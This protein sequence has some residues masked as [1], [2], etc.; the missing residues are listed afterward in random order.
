MVRHTAIFAWLVAVLVGCVSSPLP[1]PSV[2]A[3]GSAAAQPASTRA[4]T[5]TVAPP[6]TPIEFGGPGSVVLT[7]VADDATMSLVSVG[8]DGSERLLGQP[9]S[10]QNLVDGYEWEDGSISLGPGG[11]VL[12][13]ERTNR[14]DPASYRLIRVNW[15]DPGAKPRLLPNGRA[16]FLA[17]GTI[18]VADE[19]WGTA[20][21]TA[22][23]EADP[24]G[25]ALAAPARVG[26]FGT[27]ADRS[28]L[29]GIRSTETSDSNPIL[30]PVVV[31]RDGAVGP[32]L[33]AAGVALATGRERTIGAGGET[34]SQWFDDGPTGGSSGLSVVRA[35]IPDNGRNIAPG[36]GGV[37]DW[38]WTRDGRA[39][40]MLAQGAIYR[41]DGARTARVLDVPAAV[42]DQYGL[43]IVGLTD[44]GVILS[45]GFEGSTF[46]AFDGGPRRQLDGRLLEVV[47]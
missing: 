14:E 42:S 2:W 17:G 36:P 19:L 13:E 27:T 32:W 47:P 35:G 12:V 18:V 34:L 8:A 3:P 20:R 43:R 26:L 30:E 38:A 7:R 39:V 21:V 28:L 16:F 15:A 25:T 41:W 6:P 44:A 4:V 1:Q 23:E 40:V 45:N 31:G 37:S 9:R 29:V 11:I 22:F 24:D 5:P 46:L 33:S 10:L